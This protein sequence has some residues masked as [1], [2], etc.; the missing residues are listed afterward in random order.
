MTMSLKQWVRSQKKAVK[1][2][3]QK[4]RRLVDRILKSWDEA[5]DYFSPDLDNEEY[6]PFYPLD[7]EEYR[8]E[9]Y[10]LTGA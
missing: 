9:L 2:R 8:E 3:R 1:R 4:Y 7:D 10:Y 5:D 6:E